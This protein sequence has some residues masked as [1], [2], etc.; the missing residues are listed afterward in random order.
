LASRRCRMP[1]YNSSFIAAVAGTSVI[2]IA[3]ISN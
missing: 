3:T 1:V 2:V